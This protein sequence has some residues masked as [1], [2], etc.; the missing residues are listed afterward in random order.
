MS[1]TIVNYGISKLQYFKTAFP[2]R[3]LV[4]MCKTSY[5]QKKNFGLEWSFKYS[6]K[7][8]IIYKI[9]VF[10]TEFFTMQ[11]N[12]YWQKILWYSSTMWFWL[13][14]PKILYFQ[15]PMNRKSDHCALATAKAQPH[16]SPNYLRVCLVWEST[17][18]ESGPIPVSD[19]G[20]VPFCVWQA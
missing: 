6:K 13:K 5:R 9:M 11:P 16:K 2:N 18:M 3:P 20:A 14:T 7:Y 12:T 4:Y 15:T 10:K 19:N 8:Y 1:C 17:K